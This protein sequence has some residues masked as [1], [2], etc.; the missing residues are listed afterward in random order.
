M[1]TAPRPS[2]S[3]A[4]NFM[5]WFDVRARET[6]YWAYVLNRLSAIGLT[7]YL[8]LHLIILSNLARGPE[9]Y[10]AFLATIKSPIFIFGELLTV[11]G[12]FY[13]GLNGLRIALTS[14]GVAVP[15]QRQMFWASLIITI[16]VSVIFAIKMFGAGL[17]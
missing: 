4:G 14:F 13:H 2:P 15:Y 5:R 8:F 11:I 10:G 17:S 1:D 16:I 3:S 12:G 7:I 6:G 9:A